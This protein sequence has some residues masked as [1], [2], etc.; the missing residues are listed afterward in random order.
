MRGFR[1]W[2]K[3]P[4][5]EPPLLDELD[6]LLDE[7]EREGVLRVRALDDSGTYTFLNNYQNIKGLPVSLYWDGKS[8]G[9][10]VHYGYISHHNHQKGVEAERLYGGQIAFWV[11]SGANYIDVSY[12]SEN[13][14]KANR[15]IVATV[16]QFIQ[17]GRPI[18]MERCGSVWSV[19]SGR[20]SL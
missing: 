12:E 18:H 5:P 19:T 10:T 14:S 3:A 9:S 4:A 6:N 8:H 20:G 1:G 13:Y 7:F 15:A 17:A 11:G 16:L 2:K